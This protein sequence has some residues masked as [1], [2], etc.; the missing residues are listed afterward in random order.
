MR[1]LYHHRTLGRGAEGVHISNMVRA[2][3]A[4][5]N[6]VRVLSP[7]SVDPLRDAGSNVFELG[8]E[9]SSGDA[10]VGETIKSIA[11]KAPQFLFEIL[12]MLY[13][14]YGAMSIFGATKAFRPDL[15]YE[16]YAFY[17]FCGGMIEK[18]K[19]IP[20]VLEV[21]E[22]CGIK[23]FRG[24]TF[25]GLATWIE[26]KIFSRADLIIVVSSFLKKRITERGIPEEKILVLPNGVDIEK[27]QPD[28]NRSRIRKKYHL[29]ENDI[30]LGFVGWFAEWDR[31]DELILVMERIVAS[32]KNVRLMLVGDGHLRESLE[33]LIESRQL[34]DHVLITGAVPREEI[35]DYMSA[36]DIG[37][38]PHSNEF[39]SPI[40]LFELMAMKKAVVAPSL[41]P[42]TDVIRHQENGMIFPAGDFVSMERS[43]LS[44]IREEV[45]RERLGENAR[46][47]IQEKHTWRRKAETLFKALDVKV[48]T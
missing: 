18:R 11:R 47:E 46:R 36:I 6:Q 7:P 12:E 14:A 29:D 43:L 15:Y 17:S 8:N 26:K 21:N 23:R 37:V 2:F 3:E 32:E 22:I 45:L 9:N 16:R 38:L 5:G 20:F 10:P 42:I 48:N 4:L 30:V 31:L 34:K 44:L 24:Q 33:R 40:V 28:G 41:D 13:N 25:T 19:R 39:G 27:F 1:I 35:Q